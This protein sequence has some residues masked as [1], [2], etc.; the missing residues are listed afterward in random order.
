M[1]LLF[2]RFFVPLAFLGYSIRKNP[3]YRTYPI[4]QPVMMF[5]FF[6]IIVR[7]VKYSRKTNH[8]VH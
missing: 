1:P 8:M 4:M 7:C 5:G 6:W 2:A 3:F